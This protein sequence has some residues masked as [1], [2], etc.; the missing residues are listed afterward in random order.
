MS[1]IVEMLE[2]L[3][4]AVKHLERQ[5]G[6]NSEKP[7]FGS[8]ALGCM[9]YHRLSSR[10]CISPG[11]VRLGNGKTADGEK[12]L[13]ISLSGPVLDHEGGDWEDECYWVS[14]TEERARELHHLL[15]QHFYD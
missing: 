4:V 15:E 9:N 10:E 11:A 14:L 1:S 12:R 13:C 6:E 7:A 8:A 2:D 3:I 5:V